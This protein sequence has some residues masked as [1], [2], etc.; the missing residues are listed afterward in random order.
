MKGKNNRSTCPSQALQSKQK[1]DHTVCT[2][3]HLQF[4]SQ[5]HEDTY[6]L[7]NRLPLN[8]LHPAAVCPVG[9]S[10][11]FLAHLSKGSKAPQAETTEKPAFVS[12]GDGRALGF[13]NTGKLAD[14]HTAK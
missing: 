7:G 12:A 13:W 4:A 1:R 9:S 6:T 10:I 11:F 8:M 5:L 3:V 2:S 14:V